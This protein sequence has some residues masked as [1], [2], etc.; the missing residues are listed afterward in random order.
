M[1]LLTLEQNPEK[2]DWQILS[3]NPNAIHLLEQDR[4]NINWYYLSGNPKAIHILEYI[5][6]AKNL[7]EDIH[8]HFVSIP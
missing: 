5:T 6:Y 4:K 7:L 3:S 1:E 8:C 2:I